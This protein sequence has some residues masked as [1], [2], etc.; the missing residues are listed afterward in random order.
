MSPCYWC[1]CCCF[2]HLSEM[3]PT[4]AQAECYVAMRMGGSNSGRIDVYSK[5]KE[6]TPEEKVSTVTLGEGYS[7]YCVPTLCPTS[8]QVP[9]E[10]YFQ[11][12]SSSGFT[13]CTSEN[14]KYLVRYG[15]LT[16]FTKRSSCESTVSYNLISGSCS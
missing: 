4:H 13:R 7:R 3:K 2:C 8:P 10:V 5:T 6:V 11:R 15:A 12:Q 9:V 1:L 16:S 14:R